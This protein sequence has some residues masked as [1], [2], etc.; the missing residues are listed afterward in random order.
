MLPLLLTAALF[1]QVPSPSLTPMGDSFETAG[2]SSAS[3]EAIP[4]A[5][6]AVAPEK[7]QSIRLLR[8]PLETVA[9]VVTGIGV[10]LI[11]AA[12]GCGIAA[13]CNSG[14]DEIPPSA[15]YFIL[16]APVGLPIGAYLVGNALDGDGSLLGAYGGL[17]AA[18]ALSGGLALMT[19]NHF[20]DSP[21]AGTISVLAFLLGP[22]IGY[23][24]SSHAHKIAKVNVVP[25]LGRS[26]SGLSLVAQF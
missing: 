7:D 15:V 1:A 6:D 24:L 23:E 19:G 8:I 16:A 5:T 26:G 13:N 12:V 18:G 25:M 20:D 14:D 9:G 4:E 2:A 10:G 3:G 17:F 11:G 22:P 21:V